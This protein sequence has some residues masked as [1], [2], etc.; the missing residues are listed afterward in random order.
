M[1]KFLRKLFNTS[2]YSAGRNSYDPNYTTNTARPV[3]DIPGSPLL[4]VTQSSAIRSATKKSVKKATSRK[5]R[6]SSD[7]S[8]S[9]LLVAVED[10]YIPESSYSAPVSTPEPAFSGGG[11][12]F[13][14]G[15][16]GGS[17]DSGSS[18]SSSYDSGG[19]SGGGDCGGGGG[20]D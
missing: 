17:W 12:D 16:S 5:S 4:T 2:G 15:G 19:S 1:F 20:C 7:N 14:G 18:S 8:D 3:A 13:G 9:M 10:S 6:S 11:G